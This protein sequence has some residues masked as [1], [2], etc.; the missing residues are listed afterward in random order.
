MGVTEASFHIKRIPFVYMRFLE[1]NGQEQVQIRLL[2]IHGAAFY[3][4]QETFSRLIVAV[5][6]D[7]D[8]E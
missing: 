3:Q 7:Q 5:C 2:P 6:V 4:G 8:L 1:D